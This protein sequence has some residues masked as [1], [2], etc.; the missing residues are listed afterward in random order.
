MFKS[1]ISRRFSDVHSDQFHFMQL[2]RARKRK[3]ES[4]REFADRF[5]DLAQKVMCE[6]HDPEVQRI[7]PENAYRVL[8]ASFIARLTG[9]PG[10]QVRYA[11][12][13][14]SNRRCRLPLMIKRWKIRRVL[15]NLSTQS[16]TA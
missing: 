11:N 4:T 10:K 14:I 15:T 5:R 12:P 7:H 2:Q 6:V 3:D 13:Q 9:Q 8:L 1:A 16:L